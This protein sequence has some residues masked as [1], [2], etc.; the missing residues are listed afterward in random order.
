MKI[1]SPADLARY[2]DHTL[3][4]ADAGARDIERLCLEAR[5]HLFHAVCVNGSR[6]ELAAH[7]LE[8]TNV[9]VAA[10]VG[11]PLGAMEADAKR[12]ETEAALDLGAQEIDVVLN[13]G[14][15]KDGDDKY[16]LRELRDV[17]EAADERPV[18][19]IIETCLLTREEKIRA[20]HL[21]LDSGAHF[22]KT[23]TGFSSG[24]ATVEDVKLLREAVGPKF[25]VKAAGGI[26]DTATALAMIE[27]GATR[28]GTSNG[29]A[30]VTGVTAQPSGY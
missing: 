18:K 6:V 9:K 28:L 4:R 21:I 13:V 23:S 5:Q 12:F 17:V 8:D 2:I 19:V 30:I 22:V 7:L 15:L 11:F 1:D 27:A 10:V 14:R 29:V 25:G 26:R 24:G 16:L 20:C 3:L